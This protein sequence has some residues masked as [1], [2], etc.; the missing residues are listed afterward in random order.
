MNT[1]RLAKVADEYKR[2]VDA[3]ILGRDFLD[4]QIMCAPSPGELNE[5]RKAWRRASFKL[6]DVI[7]QAYMESSS[8]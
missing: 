1:L 7:S 3:Y 8:E 4:A 2:S 6:N 5:L